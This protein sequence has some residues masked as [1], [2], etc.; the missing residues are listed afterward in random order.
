MKPVDRLRRLIHFVLLRPAMWLLGLRITNR[1]Q[2]PDRGPAIVVANH[3]SHLDTA[4]LLAAFG[5]RTLDQ[6]R[7]AAA[8]DYFLRNRVARWLSLRVIGVV[9]VN[10]FGEADPLA[11]CRNALDAGNILLV[12]PEGTRGEPGR[13]ERFRSGVARLAREWP[14]VPII[15]VHIAG[16][17]R[18][19]PRGSRFPRCRGIQLSVGDPE[20]LRD[21]D[22]ATALARL[23]QHVAALG[24]AS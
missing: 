24:K 22:P 4:A 1:A 21:P 3:N 18:A 14:D 15:P 19:M 17:D 13:I 6:V 23:Q 8:A 5:T 10:R 11:G 12:F 9:P 7:P 16:T 2:L 20:Y